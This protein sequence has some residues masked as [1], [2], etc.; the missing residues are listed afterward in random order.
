MQSTSAFF[1]VTS[2]VD[3][4]SPQN[5]VPEDF[6]QKILHWGYFSQLKQNSLRNAKLVFFILGESFLFMFAPLELFGFDFEPE[7]DSSPRF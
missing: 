1:F 2:S 6:N 7:S 5:S 4:S 3:I